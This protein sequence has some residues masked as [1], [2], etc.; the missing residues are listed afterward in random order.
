MSISIGSQKRDKIQ[1][2]IWYENFW[3]KKKPSKKNMFSVGLQIFHKKQLRYYQIYRWAF[4]KTC[5]V[6]G[7]FIFQKVNLKIKKATKQIKWKINILKNCQI[8]LEVGTSFKNFMYR[9]SPTGV[10]M[11]SMP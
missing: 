7:K 3:V 10:S 6:V 9:R 11:P 1:F 8:I 5:W 2:D 4:R